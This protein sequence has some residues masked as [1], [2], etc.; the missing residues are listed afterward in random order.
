MPNRL[1][2]ATSPYL[3]QHADNPVDWYPWG[4]EA[5]QRAAAE[6]RPILLS[7][8]YSACHWCHVMA[9]ESFE[10]PETAADMNRWFVSVK[11]DREERP[12]VDAVYMEAV[13]ALTGRGGWPMTV[14]LTPDGAPFYAGTYFPKEDR[15]G[16]PGF[17]RVLAA[18]AD[19]W[20]QRR[21]EV[22]DQAGRL[23]GTIGRALPVADDLPGTP[24]LEAAYRA[25][26]GAV[27]TVHGG[28]G[29]AP[30]FP[31]QP[32]LDFLLRISGEPWA[33]GAGVIVRDALV[34]MAAGGIYDQ[35]GGG[36][37]RY[38]VDREWRIPH[39][40]KM[41]YD[42]AQLARLYLWAWRE[43]GIEAFRR[44]ATETLEYLLRDLRHPDGAFFSAE[45]ADSEGEEGRFYVWSHTEFHE[46]AGPE[47]GPPAAAVFGVT[48]A[49]N[50]EGANHLYRAR[51]PEDVAAE[52]GAAPEEVARAVE[53]T[54]ARLFE[55]RAG[56][57]RPGLDDKVIAGWNGL[58]LRAFAEAGAA[59]GESRYLE[60]ARSCAGFLL[61][62]LVVDGRLRRSW[63]KGRV[64]GV[65]GFLEDHAAVAVGLLALYA[66]TGEVEWFEAARRL[67]DEIPARFSDPDG[68]FFSTGDDAGGLIVRPRDLMDNPSPSGNSLAAEA[69]LFLALYTGEPAYRDAAEEAV[70]SGGLL[71]ERYPQGAGHLLGVAHT[72]GRGPLEVAVVGG[73]AFD[74]ARVIWERYRPHV[75]A[76][77]SLDGSESA[78]VPLLSDRFVAGRTLAYVC[79]D[80]VCGLPADGPE[81]L[82]AQLG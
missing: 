22:E 50:F 78:A 47:D 31:Q 27:D 7:V 69:F 62:R 21:G 48:K 53:R 38:A 30:K 67:G 25:L 58:A 61:D 37:A 43:S 20:E 59:L 17:R 35:I 3:L 79:R 28:F 11:V 49:G 19:A 16:M 14:F 82:R 26:A 9:H 57:V 63:G 10:D 6:Q 60:A 5:L 2:A 44:V 64:S 71:V 41:L 45:D 72:L 1:A 34:A 70:R 23:A 32:A 56:R 73:E 80:F 65:G 76:A 12:D 51:T 33:E 77:P 68:G 4:D 13:Q 39:F 81:A 36:F 15:H 42:N 74:L 18:V 75:A 54:R 66:A 24:V 52:R 46:V 40:E 29:S 8:G 55:R